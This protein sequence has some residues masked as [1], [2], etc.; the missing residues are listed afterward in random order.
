MVLVAL[1]ESV[2]QTAESNDTRS[3]REF[4]SESHAPKPVDGRF[5]LIKAL[6]L[7]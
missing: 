7:L 4:A 1:V 5:L 6:K 2:T 3:P